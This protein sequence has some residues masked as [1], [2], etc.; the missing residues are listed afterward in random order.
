[1]D[2]FR[3]SNN[4]QG[5]TLIEM[6]IVLVIIGLI[7]GAVLKGQDLIANARSKSF[8]NEIRA[9]EVA[10]WNYLD[11]YGSYTT[12]IGQ[13]SDWT[14]KGF[15]NPPDPTFELGSSKF[16]MDYTVADDRR[17]IRV[18]ITAGGDFTTGSETEHVYYQSFKNSIGE[19][20]VTLDGSDNT[21]YYFYD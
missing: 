12:S 9:A 2:R 18:A 14:A 3:K 11:R 20:A 7:I 16:S 10:Q 6:A 8:A 15:R 13:E 19:Q 5:F 21:M 4:Q 17:V 1:M